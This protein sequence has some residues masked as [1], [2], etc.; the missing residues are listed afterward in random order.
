MLVAHF[1]QS[2]LL[3]TMELA[4]RHAWIRLT[5]PQQ[6]L[7]TA[8]QFSV[9]CRVDQFSRLRIG[10]PI[11]NKQLTMLHRAMDLIYIVLRWEGRFQSGLNTCYSP[12]WMATRI[13]QILFHWQRPQ[14]KTKIGHTVPWIHKDSIQGVLIRQLTGRNLPMSITTFQFLHNLAAYPDIRN[15]WVH[16]FRLEQESLFC[17]QLFHSVRWSE[18]K[19]SHNQSL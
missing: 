2:Y 8:I 11:H 3:S 9:V 18:V 19:F 7:R 6:R 5:N 4:T 13:H 16:N 17:Q 10:F 15:Q 1:L 14:F 12:K